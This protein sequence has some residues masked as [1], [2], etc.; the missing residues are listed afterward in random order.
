MTSTN[1]KGSPWYKGKIQT[2][3]FIYANELDYFQGNV[4][5]YTVRYKK[6]NGKEDLEKAKHYLE[7]M[8]E[9]LDN[10]ANM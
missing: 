4:I 3:D 2:W 6:K 1:S 10:K 8:I 9:Q 7:K 5:K